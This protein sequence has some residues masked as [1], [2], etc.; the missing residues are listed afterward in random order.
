[1]WGQESLSPEQQRVLDRLGAS[2]ADWPE[3]DPELRPQLRAEL[4]DRLSGIATRIDP[5]QP[6]W[7]NKFALE[8][9]HG[10][11]AKF[12]ADRANKFE[13]SPPLARGSVSHKAIELAIMRTDRPTSLALVD[14]AIGSLTNADRSLGDWLRTC[15]ETARAEVRS[16]ANNR[17]AA[18]MECFPPLKEQWNPRLEFQTQ[19]RLADGRIFLSGKPDLTLGQND[20]VRAGKVI[21]D[22]KTGRVSQSHAA[23]L[24]FYALLEALRTGLPPRMVASY[25]LDQG[26]MHTESITEESLRAAVDRV[27]DAA[28]RIV[29]LDAEERSPQLVTG[30]PC[31]W[32]GIQPDCAEGT[33]YLTKSRDDGS[34]DDDIL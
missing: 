33:A 4:E 31:R 22:Y 23:D 27:V 8:A 7:L 28:G 15:G 21:V 5:A 1:M 9:V 19:A 13:W 25:Y 10:C 6:L 12:L 29:T 20:G 26:D 11:E 16:E 17:V 30:P 18:F 34:L 24:R 3:F 32:C 14:D 2:R